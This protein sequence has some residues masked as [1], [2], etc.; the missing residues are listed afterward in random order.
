MS[1][2]A[3][4]LSSLAACALSLSPASASAALSAPVHLRVE[5]LLP[6]TAVIS[7]P[8]PRFSFIHDNGDDSP[9]DTSQRPPPTHLP[10]HTHTTPPPA[11]T[12]QLSW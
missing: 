3:L 11:H 5:N 10:T 2:V 7:E 4:V 8:R 6:D 9:G 1:M 12:T